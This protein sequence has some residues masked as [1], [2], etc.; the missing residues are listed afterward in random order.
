MAAIASASRAL[1]SATWRASA[2]IGNAAQ[3][4]IASSRMRRSRRA[5]VMPG[6][7]TLRVEADNPRILGLLWVQE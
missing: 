7:L 3:I 1:K 4:T 6:I 2:A 5:P